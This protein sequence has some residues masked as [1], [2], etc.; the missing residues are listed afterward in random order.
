[1]VD[2]MLTVTDRATKMVVIIPCNTRWNAAEMAAVS[3]PEPAV[4]IRR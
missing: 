2:E 4:R 3:E 1:M